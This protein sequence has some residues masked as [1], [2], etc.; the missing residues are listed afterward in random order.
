MKKIIIIIAILALAGL[1]WYL[2][3]QRPSSSTDTGRK[4]GSAVKG[5]TEDVKEGAS[6][7]AETVKE[8]GQKALES[9]KDFGKGLKEGWQ[10]K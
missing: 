10:S 6:K 8:G 9:A 4:L 5:A 1:G 7:A 2:Y 3:Q